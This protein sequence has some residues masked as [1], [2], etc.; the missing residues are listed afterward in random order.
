MKLTIRLRPRWIPYAWRRVTPGVNLKSFA[1]LRDCKLVLEAR[2][3]PF[4]IW[5]VRDRAYFFAP[6]L[7]E[8]LARAELAAYRDELARPPSKKRPIPV[9]QS[10]EFAYLW[11]LPLLL[12]YPLQHGSRFFAALPPPAELT[13]LGSLNYAAV[14]F[15][16]QYYRA[17]TAMTLHVDVSHLAG[18]S[19][20]GAV[21]LY[22]LARAV[23]YGSAFLLTVFAGGL[24]NLAC[25]F[26]RTPGYVSVG[27]STAV[28]ASLGVLAGIMIRR[29][30]DPRKMFVTLAAAV[31]LLAMLGAEGE[32]S[33]YG[34]HI[35]GLAAGLFTG[36]IRGDKKARLPQFALGALGL[37]LLVCAWIIAL[38]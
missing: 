5:R 15:H 29:V 6:A 25:V 14:V 9:H 38:I 8:T 23:G 2:G 26:F 13:G 20:F 35:A 11:L 34:A 30:D 10:A 31:A 4:V 32:R 12:F 17:F 18:N 24:A 33:D 28:F 21:F 1:R 7:L 3:I 16:K 19:F 27:F 36:F 37:A 22:M